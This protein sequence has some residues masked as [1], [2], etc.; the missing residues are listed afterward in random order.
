MRGRISMVHTKEGM[1]GAGHVR[2][3]LWCSPEVKQWLIIRAMEEGKTVS[4][5]LEDTIQA[6]IKGDQL[7][8][9]P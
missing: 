3:Q 8:G 2:L 5:V 1:N 6:L 9:L 7:R 4:A